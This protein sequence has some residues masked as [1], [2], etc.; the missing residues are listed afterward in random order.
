[1]PRVSASSLIFRIF[2]IIIFVAHPADAAAMTTTVPSSFAMTASDDHSVII[3]GAM[4]PEFKRPAPLRGRP[5]RR[6]PSDD[7]FQCTDS[8]QHVTPS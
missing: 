8:Y 4:G 3:L 5:S 7:F 6:V 1:M 2:A